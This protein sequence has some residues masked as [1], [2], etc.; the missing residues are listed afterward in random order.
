[1]TYANASAWAEEYMDK[2]DF[3]DFQ[4]WLEHATVSSDNGL[5]T[6]ELLNSDDFVN[7]MRDY[8]L[9]EVGSLKRGEEEEEI[10]EDYKSPIYNDELPRP[11]QIH[12]DS[13]YVVTRNGAMPVKVVDAK[14]DN[15]P[16]VVITQQEATAQAQ[17]SQPTQQPIPTRQPVTRRNVSSITTKISS[18]LSGFAKSFTGLF[19]RKR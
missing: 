18:A 19:R 9:N 6:P 16:P 7:S 2:D 10:Y 12:V 1:M 11:S 5:R 4:D 14:G 17:P 13:G 8:W 3:D 15:Q